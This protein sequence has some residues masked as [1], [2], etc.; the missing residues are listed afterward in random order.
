LFILLHF[1]YS[2]CEKRNE[3]SQIKDVVILNSAKY[4]RNEKKEW[5]PRIPTL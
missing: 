5:I 1:V 3:V 4:L 2:I